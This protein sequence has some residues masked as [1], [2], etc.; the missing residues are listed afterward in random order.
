VCSRLLNLAR[1]SVS[2]RPSTRASP[3]NL[4]HRLRA[5]RRPSPSNIVHPRPT[6]R[7]KGRTWLPKQPVRSYCRQL[8]VPTPVLRADGPRHA[9]GD[10]NVP[11]RT[12][13]APKFD[14]PVDSNIFQ[15]FFIAGQPPRRGSAPAD[16]AAGAPAPGGSGAGR[17][18]RFSCQW[19]QAV[20]LWVSLVLRALWPGWIGSSGLPGADTWWPAAPLR[21]R[22]HEPRPPRG[23]AWGSRRRHGTSPR[24]CR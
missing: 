12:Q 24:R 9:A 8:K 15:V 13:Y 4:G 6:G 7:V 17:W 21:S 14:S 19:A 1:R 11:R 20:F 22:R 10:R 16:V 18:A 2:R 23:S 5:S 3:K